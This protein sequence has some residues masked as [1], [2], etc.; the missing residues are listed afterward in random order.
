MPCRPAGNAG[1]L[2]P[3]LRD[4]RGTTTDMIRARFFFFFFYFFQPLAGER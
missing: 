4:R 1:K 3:G 2:P